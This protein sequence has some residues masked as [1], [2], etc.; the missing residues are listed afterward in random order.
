MF[1]PDQIFTHFEREEDISNLRGK[2]EDDLLRIHEIL[3]KA[4]PNSL[5]I[6]NE[7]FSSTT[8]KDAVELS[9]KVMAQF[10]QLDLLAVWVTFLD[11]LSSFN[12]KTVSMIA[13]VDSHDPA[14]RTYKLE[15]RL[16]NGLA[17]ALAI[18]QK[19]RV[20]YESLKER[21]QS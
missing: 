18:A 7:V 10:C 21:L 14:I 19:H 12:D 6:M 5:V 13:T 20:T 11:E 15:R 17:Y 8:L 1:I 9:K 3:R 2:L 16:A 4:T